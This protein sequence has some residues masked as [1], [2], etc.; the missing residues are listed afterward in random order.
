MYC[1]E[2][3]D[4]IMIAHSLPD[5]FFGPAAGLHGATFVVD[6]AF[7]RETLTGQNVVVD[8]GAAQQALAAVRAWLGEGDY[9]L[10]TIEASGGTRSPIGG[11]LWDAAAG[12]VEAADP[13]AAL[14][15]I[16]VAGFTD[17]HW[18]RDAFGTVA[19]G[20]FPSR[21]L[22]AETAARLIHSHDERVPVEW[23]EASHRAWP[24][25]ELF[26]VEGPN[27]RNTARD[28][29]VIARVLDYLG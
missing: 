12:W 29:R 10:E 8:I 15:P 24:C 28:P 21:T 16:C 11:R 18:L 17:S 3:R 27:H 26:T 20:F 5:P 7:F 9:E 23:A 14:A 19:Y 22:D 25:A 1:V 2:V 4:R 6:V 13:G